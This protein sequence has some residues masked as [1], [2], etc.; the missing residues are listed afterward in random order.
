[1]S[2]S[3][4]VVLCILDGWG[5]RSETEGNAVALGRTPAFDRI[6][7]VNARGVVLGH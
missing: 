6:M 2:I 7:A 3:G 5:L 1:M 4:P